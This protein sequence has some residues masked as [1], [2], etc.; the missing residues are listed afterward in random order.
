[1]GAD[2]RSR[3][4]EINDSQAVAGPEDRA[5]ADRNGI[6]GRPGKDPG[7]GLVLVIDDIAGEIRDIPVGRGESVGFIGAESEGVA[8][9]AGNG[10]EE[11]GGVDGRGAGA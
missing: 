5:V 4:G 6:M 9:N 11:A 10:G 2:V 3:T 8:G 7:L 1:M